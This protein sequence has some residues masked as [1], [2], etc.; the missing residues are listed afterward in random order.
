[1]LERSI[2]GRHI[3]GQIGRLSLR[4][5]MI[6]ILAVVLTAMSLAIIAVGVVYIFYTESEAWSGR[7]GDA[8]LNAAQTVSGYLESIEGALGLL[9]RFS[10]DEIQSDPEILASLVH[11]NAAFH[12]II[13]LEQNGE[14]VA[15]GHD[16]LAILENAFT[17]TQSEWFRAAKSGALFYS[18]VHISPDNLPYIVLS[19][20][21]QDNLLIAARL[22]MVVLWDV[23]SQIRVG[24]YGRSF[25]VNRE[26]QVIAHTDYEQVLAGQ[27]VALQELAAAWEQS[28]EVW[29]GWRRNLDGQMVAS[30]AAA[31]QGTNWLIV[32]ELPLREAYFRSLNA[33]W[34]LVLGMGVLG[35]FTI[36]LIGEFMNLFFLQPVD[37]LRQGAQRLGRGEMDFRLAAQR[38]DELGQV[39]DAFDEMA[40]RL[41]M[42]RGALEQHAAE[43]Q[44]LNVSLE[45]R[46]AHRTAELTELNQTLQREVTER[47]QAENQARASL[48]EKEILLKEVHHRVKNNLQ[49]ISSLLNLQMA[50]THDKNAGELLTDSQGRIRSMA[51]I[52]EKLYQSSDLAHVNLCSYVRDLAG[53]LFRSYRVSLMQVKLEIEAEDVYLT[54][55]QAVPCGLALNELV[56]NA[57]KHAFPGGRSGTILIQISEERPGQVRLMVKDDGIGFPEG[58]D[59]ATAPSLGLQLVNNLALQLDGALEMRR[60][61]GSMFIL[62]FP[63]NGLKVEE[64]GAG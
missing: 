8:A 55:D 53:A 22:N 5:Q 41:Q 17:V 42:Q 9:S 57:L 62:T 26:G 23:V 32:T 30:T 37:A 51:L 47:T 63:K 15:A 61:Q 59:I 34:Q 2:L 56:A 21:S 48:A 13:F 27:V 6:T 24:N 52:H 29:S 64:Y 35:F 1:M 16:D 39:M 28:G 3:R 4:R 50:K 11:E 58:L 18:K 43:V 36:A 7:Q 10:V 45:A 20:P 14:I 33:I 25:I 19:L 60:G 40:G 12:E 44:A 31:I 46:V 49:V 54:V 38:Q